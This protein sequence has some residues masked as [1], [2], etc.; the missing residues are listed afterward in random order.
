M[1]RLFLLLAFVALSEGCG[2]T[3]WTKQ[4]GTEQEYRVDAYACERDM[5]Q[6][7]YYGGGIAGALNAKGFYER[8]MMSKGYHKATKEEIDSPGFTI[9]GK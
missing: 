5:R 7:G 2:Q 8:C 3:I 9:Y 4:G 1:V 6:S